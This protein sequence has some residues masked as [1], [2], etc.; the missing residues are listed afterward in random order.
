MKLGPALKLRALFDC[1]L[2]RNN[3][4][5]NRQQMTACSELKNM[6]NSGDSDCSANLTMDSKSE[7]AEISKFL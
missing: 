6:D 4:E 5:N 7:N 2:D 3:E 1:K